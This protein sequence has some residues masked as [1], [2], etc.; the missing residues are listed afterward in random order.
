MIISE[1]GKQM[2]TILAKYMCTEEEIAAE[3][4]TTVDTLHNRNN[5]SIFSECLKKGRLKGKSSLRRSQF[6]LAEKN[7]TMA[8]FLGKNYLDQ[9]DMPEH[10]VVEDNSI[11][12]NYDY[13]EDSPDKNEG[14]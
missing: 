13:G 8:I 5:A 7:A 1:E 3:L 10:E 4:G 2:I 12:I 6:K 14:E 9:K 11:T